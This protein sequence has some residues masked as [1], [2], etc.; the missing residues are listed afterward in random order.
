MAQASNQDALEVFWA[1]PSRQSW[2]QDLLEGL[3][4]LPGLVVPQGPRGELESVAGEK[5]AWNTLLSQLPL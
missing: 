3:N 4:V 5:E 2:A 1:R